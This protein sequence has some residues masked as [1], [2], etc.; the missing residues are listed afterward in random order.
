MK[1]ASTVHARDLDQFV[2]E[3]DRFGDP[4]SPACAAYIRDFNLA[5]DTPVDQDLDPF[6]DAYVAQM[7]ALYEEISGRKLDQEKGEM[8]VIDVAT[9]AA[10]VSPY[11]STDTRFLSKHNRAVTTALMLANL[12]PGAEVLDAGC[13]WGLSSEAMAFSGARVTALDINPLFVELVRTRAA[14]LG[15]PIDAVL[16][17]FDK[18]QTGKRFDLLLFYE[19][20]HH[21]VK[22]WETL[23][24]LGQ[25]VKPEGK[26]VFAGEPINAVWWRHWGIRLDPLAVYC[27]RKF[28]WFESGWTR[29]FIARC[30]ARAGFDLTIYPNVGL[31]CDEIGYAKRTGETPAAGPELTAWHRVPHILSDSPAPAAVAPRVAPV[32][33]VAPVTAALAAARAGEAAQ[34][35]QAA[36]AGEEA[37]LAAQVNG[38]AGEFHALKEVV[39]G[40]ASRRPAAEDGLA[41]AARLNGQLAEHQ[42]EIGRMR[43]AIESMRASR[44]WR[45]TAPVRALLGALGLTR[46]QGVT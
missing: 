11:N 22:P 1:T 39:A 27:I 43:H 24:H 30:F 45:A 15:L 34:A 28:G 5:F 9:H 42:A 31:N 40:L 8:T 4:N 33:A 37:R 23:A 14:R 3:C 10:A 35:R 7:V 13:G 18:Y 17:E 38:L 19:C 26:V 2:A 20:L 12:P 36:G 6:S 44:S 41:L 46:T 16:A 21:S 32:A 29:E 25:F